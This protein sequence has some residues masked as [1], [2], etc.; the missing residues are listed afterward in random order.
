MA[1]RGELS[2][3]TSMMTHSHGLGQMRTQ[4]KIGFDVLRVGVR[5]ML[6]YPEQERKTR[7]QTNVVSKVHLCLSMLTRSVLCHAAVPKNSPASIDCMHAA[8]FCQARVHCQMT[9]RYCRSYHYAAHWN[10][11]PVL[12]SSAACS[13]ASCGIRGPSSRVTE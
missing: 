7:M 1:V 11:P 12:E 4:R 5:S 3:Q 6:K 10:Q 13:A 8:T 9:R 2:R